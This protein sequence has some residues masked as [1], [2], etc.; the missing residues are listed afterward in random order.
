MGK[1]IIDCRSCN[2]LVS[3]EISEIQDVFGIVCPECGSEDVL[4]RNVELD[5]NNDKPLVLGRGGCS[6]K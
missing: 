3:K 4:I 1:V 2:R 5:N 6:Q